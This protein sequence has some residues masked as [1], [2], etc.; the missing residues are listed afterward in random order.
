MNSENPS[1]QKPALIVTTLGSFIVPFMGSS[2]NIALPS[3][4]RE[5]SLDALMLNWVTTSYLMSIAAFLLPFG[6]ISDIYGIKKI[7]LLGFT[8]FTFFSFF[9]ALS[10]SVSFL[11]GSRIL[12]GIGASMTAST[13]VAILSSVFPPDKKGSV[14]GI[15]VA[16]VYTGLSCGPFFGGLL[17]QH[18]GWRSIF[19]IN[20]PAGLIII[21]YSLLQLKGEWAEARGEKFDWLGSILYSSALITMMF[22]FFQMSSSF[23]IILLFLGLIGIWLFIRWELRV[24]SPV[25]EMRLLTENRVFAFSN[26]AALINYS[27]TF[28]LNFLLSLYLQ[29]VRGL[30]PQEAGLILVSAPVMQALFS[31]FAGRISDRIEP[32]KVASVGMTL[33]TLGLFFFIFLDERTALPKI[34]ACLLLLGFGFALFS[35]PNTNAVMSSVEKRSYGVASGTLSTMRSVGMM[36]SMGLVMVI[37]S[38]FMGR[39][40]IAPPY[41][42]LFLK[43]VRGAFLLFTILCALGIGASLARGPS[44]ETRKMR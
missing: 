6:R 3:I 29:S 22:G 18:L 32:R 44:P 21:V 41:F 12:Q 38:I 31:P 10:P 37:F 13:G 20:I 34:V 4:G 42:H 17:T 27:A 43:S 30:K 26:L 19:F 36:F 16:A 1:Y 14:L 39:I 25:F 8:L 2:I 15:N 28:A 11:I 9:S 35:S 33:T 23:G 40:P 7:F 24:K 5:F